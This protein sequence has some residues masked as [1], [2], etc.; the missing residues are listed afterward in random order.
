MA[1]S[2]ANTFGVTENTTGLG[3]SLYPNPNN[4]QFRIDMTSPK[5][6]RARIAVLNDAGEYVWE[7]RDVEISGNRTLPVSLEGV[8]SGIY[9]LRI[10]TDKGIYL[11]K[12]MINN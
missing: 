7:N 11:H 12:F 4:G 5:S 3:I 8:A 10:Q 1:V 6:A 9:L 2:V